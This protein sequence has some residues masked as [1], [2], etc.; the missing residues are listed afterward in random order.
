MEMLLLF[1][2]SASVGGN[3]KYSMLFKPPLVFIREIVI[4]IDLLYMLDI[5]IP[6]ELD[7][8]NQGSTTCEYRHKIQGFI[9]HIIS[10]DLEGKA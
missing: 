9:S 1:Q 5:I 4:H 2:V 3:I 10:C 8:F 7:C 6:K